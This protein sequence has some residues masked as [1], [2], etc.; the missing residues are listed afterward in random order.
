MEAWSVLALPIFIPIMNE[1]TTINLRK[2]VQYFVQKF[3]LLHD[4]KLNPY[5]NFHFSGRQSA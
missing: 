3:P 1:I 4:L 5:E 2:I